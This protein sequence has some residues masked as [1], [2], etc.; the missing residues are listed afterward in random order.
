MAVA[1]EFKVDLLGALGLVALAS[2][3]KNEGREPRRECDECLQFLS[4][5][6]WRSTTVLLV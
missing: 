2:K 6:Y 3:V 1:G 5:Q 4:R